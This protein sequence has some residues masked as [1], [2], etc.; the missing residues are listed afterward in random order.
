MVFQH[1]SR[2]AAHWYSQDIEIESNIFWESKACLLTLHSYL[3]SRELYARGGNV[4]ARS[5]CSCAPNVSCGSQVWLEDRTRNIEKPIY[6]W[7]KIICSHPKTSH[8]SLSFLS[9]TLSKL[10]TTTNNIYIFC[11]QCWTRKKWKWKWISN[12]SGTPCRKKKFKCWV[13]WHEQ[14]QKIQKKAERVV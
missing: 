4:T 14:E 9:S 2:R 11:Y 13:F 3:A 7:I 12:K 5:G 10:L 8:E 6:L 1:K